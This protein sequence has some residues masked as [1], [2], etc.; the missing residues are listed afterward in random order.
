MKIGFSSYSLSGA[1]RDGR[2]D[3]LAAIRWIAEHGG[4]HI[5]LAPFGFSLVDNDALVEAVKKEAANC[6]LALSSYTVGANFCTAGSDNHDI[7]GD[8][9]AQMLADTKRHVDIAAAL[10]VTLMRHDAGS[11]PREQCTVE[12]FER[13]LPR[14]ADACRE[15]ADYAA[16]SGITTSVENHGYH[17]QGSERVRRLVRLVDRPNYRTTLDVGNFLCVDEDP[18]CATMNNIG[19]ASMVHFKD[20]YVRDFVSAPDSWFPSSHGRFLRGSVTGFGDVDLRGVANV[21]KAAG[22]DG[23]ISIE[24]EGHEDCLNACRLG[25]ASVKA[26]FTGAGSTAAGDIPW[27]R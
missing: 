3:I 2:M 20:F 6:G 27:V 4:E 13:D 1:I 5:E 23:F 26:L 24:Y 12:N 19:I 22:Y 25:L 17:F 16:K 21:I 7:T 9:Y 10:G 14:V 18:V 15:V 11:R 8:E